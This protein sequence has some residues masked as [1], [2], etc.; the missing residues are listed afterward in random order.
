MSSHFAPRL[1]ARRGRWRGLASERLKF[2]RERART[3]PDPPRRTN[4][5]ARSEAGGDEREQLVAGDDGLRGCDVRGEV[6]VVVVEGDALADERVRS[7]E[8]R[9]RRERAPEIDALGCSQQL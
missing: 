9:A 2:R 6:A 5:A 8:R 3:P 7:L 1:H 4:S